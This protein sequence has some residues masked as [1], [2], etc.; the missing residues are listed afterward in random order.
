M[1]HRAAVERAER[2]IE[3]VLHVEQLGETR[4]V[5]RV[6]QPTQLCRGDGALD[7]DDGRRGAVSEREADQAGH[8][9]QSC[10]V[11]DFCG[12]EGRQVDEVD[13]ELAR[14]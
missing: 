10:L 13:S 11:D 6:E 9:F 7:P 5:H 14:Q 2:Q 12:A 8:R 4:V 3:R 1:I